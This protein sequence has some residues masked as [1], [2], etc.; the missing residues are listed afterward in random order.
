MK[1]LLVMRRESHK[2]EVLYN[3]EMFK[4]NGSTHEKRFLNLCALLS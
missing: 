3:P 4:G 2:S 1:L